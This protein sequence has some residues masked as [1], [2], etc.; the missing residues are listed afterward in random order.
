MAI[1]SGLFAYWEVDYV[2]LDG[3]YCDPIDMDEG[4]STFS[5][6]LLATGRPIVYSCS[7]PFYQQNIGLTVS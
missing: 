1:D 3:C 6:Y 5:R 7:W 4:Y 2:K